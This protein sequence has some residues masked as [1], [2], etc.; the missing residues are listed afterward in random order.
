MCSTSLTSRRGRLTWGG[1]TSRGGRH[2]PPSRRRGNAR[3]PRSPLG[4]CW[5]RSCRLAADGMQSLCLDEA[6]GT[7]VAP[8]NFG[9]AA[10]GGGTE[11]E[12]AAQGG[13]GD[14]EWR[15][16][17][18]DGGDRSGRYD[19]SL[20]HFRISAVLTRLYKSGCS[21]PSPH[22]LWASS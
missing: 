21:L 6:E 7:A 22:S 11:R 4:P 13:S 10:K 3:F 16:W 15:G 8:D 1:G 2:Q 12:T 19:S 9:G 5:N 14:K 17:Q 20:C 18:K